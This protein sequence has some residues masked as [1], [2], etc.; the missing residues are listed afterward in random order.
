MEAVAITRIEDGARKQ[1]EDLVA[2][3][4]PLT[5]NLG[6]KELVTLL[7]SPDNLEDLVRGFMFTSGIVKNAS[8]IT[9]ITL[10]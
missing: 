7:C 1:A 6:G 8:Q 2:R 5:L 10:D 3:E 4:V 9:G